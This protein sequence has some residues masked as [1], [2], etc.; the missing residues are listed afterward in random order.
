MGMSHWVTLKC[1]HSVTN[2]HHW[3][4][5][6]DPMIYQG[7][8]KRLSDSPGL[9]KRSVG[10]VPYHRLPNGGHEVDISEKKK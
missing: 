5:L 1:S 10:L 6:I 2:S 7:M 9:V 3:L 4:D 8:T